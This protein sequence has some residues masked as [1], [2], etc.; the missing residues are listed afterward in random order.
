MRLSTIRLAIIAL[1][2]ITLTPPPA[3][4]ARRLTLASQLGGGARDTAFGVAV[5][6]Q[7]YVYVVGYTDSPD[8]PL[9][10]ALPMPAPD[11][12]NYISQGFITKLTPSG[13][14]IVYSTFFGGTGSDVVSGVAVDEHGTAYVVGT[15]ESS[16]FPV[17]VGRPPDG[18]RDGFVA[19]IDASGALLFSTVVGG[20]DREVISVGPGLDGAGGV[21]VAGKTYSTDV[22][23]RDPLFSEPSA[24][25][26]AKVDATSG[27]LLEGSYFGSGGFTN[28]VEGISV[29]RSGSLYLTG[30]S[31][32]GIPTTPGA[33]QPE[34]AGPIA[35]FV[36]KIDREASR[37]EYATY[38]GGTLGAGP[39]GVAVD[40]AGN[41][42]VV[43]YTYSDDFPT[44]AAALQKTDPDPYVPGYEDVPPKG[45]DAFMAK[46]APDGSSLVYATYLGGAYRPGGG[47]LSGTDV[48]FAVAVDASDNVYLAGYAEDSVGLP[49]RRAVQSASAGGTDAIVAKFDRAGTRLA[50]STYLGSR[51]QDVAYGLAAS[52]AGDVFV[53]GQAGGGD[54]PSANQ[55]QPPPPDNGNAF[56]VRL[57]TTNLA[58]TSG[59]V[60]GG[61]GR[62]LRVV[63]EGQR[64]KPGLRVF[65]GAD[66]APWPGVK[67]QGS[68]RVVLRGAGLEERFPIGA[69]VTVRVEGEDGSLA[70]VVVTR[71]T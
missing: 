21:W 20:S 24:S 60:L 37:L 31:N 47:E 66:E 27:E 63:L 1:L 28:S 42:L 70:S 65:V 29:D 26:F 16:D 49:I 55:L 38:L 12:F 25:Y 35:G 61:G 17:T 62:P 32:G 34:P 10:N 58:L 68:T 36:A 5:D 67:I 52:P 40:S 57:D 54:F 18:V 46:L 51:G 4:A 9:V 43:G 53:V 33:F 71:G 11:A 8:F 64:L 39:Y 50:Y 45:L 19:A 15:T 56:L 7:G 23:L 69:P 22:P 41:A 48:A 13:T 30:F 3:L 2:A 44:T 14:E 6:E 59:R